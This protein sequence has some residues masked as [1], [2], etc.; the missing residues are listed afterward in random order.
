MVLWVHSGNP[1]GPLAKP[2]GRGA[3]KAIAVF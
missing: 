1:V 3:A 2:K